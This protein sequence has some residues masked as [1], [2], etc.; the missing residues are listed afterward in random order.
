MISLTEENGVLTIQS[1]T[2]KAS[3]PKL[4]G[5]PMKSY[6]AFIKA[7]GWWY[8]LVNPRDNDL[9]FENVYRSLEAALIEFEMG[10]EMKDVDED[11]DVGPVYASRH[12]YGRDGEPI[13]LETI[14]LHWPS[15]DE[16]DEDYLWVILKFEELKNSFS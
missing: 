14:P 2:L 7:E 4:R 8:T 10:D 9:R 6:E 13:D 12:I 3:F 16:W 15:W 5:T 1:Q 11:E